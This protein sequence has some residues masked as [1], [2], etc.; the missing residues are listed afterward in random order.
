MRD[1]NS[2]GVPVEFD[3]PAEERLWQDLSELPEANP[4]PALR[5]RF[6]RELESASTPTLTRIERWLGLDRRAG[7]LTAAA[8]LIVG[9]VVGQTIAVPKQ[10]DDG[11]FAALEA[12]VAML[13]RSLI[14]DRLESSSPTKRLRGIIDAV[15][16]VETDD[17]I[18]NAL[19]Q[20]AIDDS[21]L[22]VRSAAIDALGPQVTSP[23]VGDEL[24]GLLE[25][26]DSPL[27]Q[28][29]LV[30]LIL[31]HGNSDQV[32]QLLRLA[33]EGRLHADLIE[34]VL[35]SVVRSRV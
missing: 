1:K 14:L 11:A 4:S 18:A 3:D 2:A 25:S 27:V 7:W 23:A 31:R 33:E 21:V 35:S 13:N 20:R 32:R 9:I 16:V 10:T 15:N 30:D 24:M 29:A 26:A 17:Q 8:T 22:S 12:Q 5:D 34:H 28:L 19:L 6:Y